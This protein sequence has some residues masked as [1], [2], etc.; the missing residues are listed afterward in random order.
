M[1]SKSKVFQG[2]IWSSI[3]RFGTMIIS[4]IANLILAR[5]LTPNEFGLV[6][7]LMF[8]IALANIL[9]DSGLGSAI[10]QK[11]DS[12]SKDYSTVFTINLILSVLIYV[13][14]YCSAPLISEFYGIEQ[15]SPILRIEGIMLFGNALCL[16][17]TSI[18]RKELRFKK[19]SCINLIANAA[20]AILGISLALYGFGVWSLVYR[21]VS[22]SII[23]ACG[24]WTTTEWKPRIT[25]SWESFKELFGF[26][27]FMLLSSLVTTST[28]NV[29][30]LIIGKYYGQSSLGY[31]TQAQSLR[32][33][34]ADSIS[35]VISQVLYPDYSN[36]QNNNSEMIRKLNT[37]VYIISFY[38]VAIIALMITIAE[39]LILFLYGEKWIAAV[40][41][42]KILCVG[43]IFYSLQDINFFIVAAKGKSRLLLISNV[44]LLIFLTSA[45]VVSGMTSSITVMVWCIA[46][47]SLI[48]YMLY[49]IL[50]TSILYTKISNQLSSLLKSLSSSII[51][52]LIAA[53]MSLCF[54]FSRLSNIVEIVLI[55]IIFITVFMV[56][57]MILKPM[58]YKYVL[59]IIRK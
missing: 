9:I 25:I 46:L 22:I 5:I 1:G 57:N 36:N 10:I 53:G 16:V 32:N 55:A 54:N 12:T 29:Q 50:A 41:F 31:V 30:N 37:G 38:T 17:Q 7:M 21:T 3:Q 26:G 11:K 59:N 4:F 47:N 44:L 13:A 27:G 58:P 20:G 39:P 24:L 14:L 51:P 28:K 48:A 23:T 56:Q 2:I 19:L 45:L 42:F 33:M 40:P 6:G 8:F 52:Y 18:L 49:A 35:S 43:G 15:L 34:V